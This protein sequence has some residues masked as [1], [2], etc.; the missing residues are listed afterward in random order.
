MAATHDLGLLR[1]IAASWSDSV[2]VASSEYAKALGL[3][4]ASARASLADRQVAREAAEKT[5]G[6]IER[7]IRAQLD[8]GDLSNAAALLRVLNDCPYEKSLRVATSRASTRSYFDSLISAC[9]RITEQAKKASAAKDESSVAEEGDRL[10]ADFRREVLKPLN[11]IAATGQFDADDIQTVY[12][13]AVKSGDALTD[14]LD[15]KRGHDVSLELSELPMLP[16]RLQEVE[17]WINELQGPA[18][19][20]EGVELE[21]ASR[22]QEAADKYRAALSY[23][24]PKHVDA[25]SERLARCERM[26]LFGGKLQPLHGSP[27]LETL[28]GIGCTFYG[29]SGEAADG[30]YVTTHWFVALYFPI[31]PLG[32]YLVKTAVGGGWH[33]LG[34][35][36]LLRWQ[37]CYTAVL[38]LAVVAAT[39][40]AA[41]APTDSGL[42]S[43]TSG[44][45]S[46]EQPDSSSYE[47]GS[48]A[49][50]GSSGSES[51][52]ASAPDPSPAPPDNSAQMES[53]RTAI[54][55]A[56]RQTSSWRPQLDAWRAEMDRTQEQ[57]RTI[58]AEKGS[59][60]ETAKRGEYVDEQRYD[61][62]IA[63]ANSLVSSYNQ[64]RDQ[65]NRLV[66]RYNAL[67]N[68]RNAKLHRLKTLEGG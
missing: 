12:D 19:F 1:V 4:L 35:L 46:V 44:P 53:L 66:D 48:S 50:E 3:L 23:C 61:T 39:M 33:L 64:L 68:K 11:H 52:D 6:W 56:D 10:L 34:K 40:F 27:S 57:I 5:L 45:V 54:E 15:A 22:W 32:R 55:K 17:K 60:E 42:S 65:H 18:L 16:S 43:D 14:F 30:S 51:S 2:E 62:L 47:Q 7:H 37:K 49:A 38:V 58:K 59:I 36:P 21:N 31:I 24:G 25:V 28:N 41:N 63:Q 13:A 67:V 9:R 26:V 20:E 8:E 29:R